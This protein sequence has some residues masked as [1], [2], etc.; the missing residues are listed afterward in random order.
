MFNYNY[1]ILSAFE[2]WWSKEP[3]LFAPHPTRVGCT[4]FKR[5]VNGSGDW[6]VYH[7]L[8][9]TGETFPWQAWRNKCLTVILIWIFLPAASCCWGA[10]L[11]QTSVQPTPIL[12][13]WTEKLMKVFIWACSWNWE[14]YKWEQ[15][16]GC[17]FGVLHLAWFK[18]RRWFQ[19]DREHW[20]L[21]S[22]SCKVGFGLCTLSKKGLGH[23]CSCKRLSTTRWSH[24][25]SVSSV[26]GPDQ[27]NLWKAAMMRKGAFGQIT[28]PRAHRIA[29]ECGWPG[30]HP[31]TVLP[32]KMSRDAIC[33]E[34]KRVRV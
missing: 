12:L 2:L 17:G 20:L 22:W 19:W 21:G 31:C 29:A 1:N 24:W 26:L 7:R 4:G 16:R 28:S 14:T 3:Y 27:T 11:S 10:E 8:S 6:E 5:W 33:S 25:D 18:G 30:S 13:L 34:C 9:H 32:K 15:L 23:I